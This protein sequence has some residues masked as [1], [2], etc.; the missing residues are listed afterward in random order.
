MKTYPACYKDRFGVQ[1]SSSDVFGSIHTYLMTET[2]S[3]LIWALWLP[4]ASAALVK[5]PLCTILTKADK[6]PRS[7]MLQS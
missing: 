3:V 4:K 5:L 7:I 6:E 1:F 2:H